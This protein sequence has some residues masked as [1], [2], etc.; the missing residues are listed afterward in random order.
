MALGGSPA[1]R[2]AEALLDIAIRENAV[3]A[4]RASLDRLAAAFGRDTVRALRDPRLGYERRRTAV[5][6]AT[7]D[8]PRAVRAVLDLL[9]QRDRI[10]IVPEV[11]RAY[12]DLVD[13]RA[14]IVKARITTS[15]ELD[16][17]QRDDL[18]RR[19]ESASGKKVRATFAVDPAI[20]GGAKVQLGDRLIDTSLR[21]QLNAL[22]RQLAG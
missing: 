14:G 4:Y 6:A 8:E 12:A 18:L 5:D 13:A 7:H 17:A 15:V 3:D 9:L 10:A 22:A 20:L 11:A 2:Y 21:T 16:A 1:R 19:L